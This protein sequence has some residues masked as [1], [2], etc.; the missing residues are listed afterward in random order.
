V[1]LYRR[2]QK[3]PGAIE[4]QM[5][6]MNRYVEK[7]D[8]RGEAMQVE[9]GACISEGRIRQAEDGSLTH[10]GVFVAVAPEVPECWA[11]GEL[12]M[13]LTVAY[14]L[15]N[16]TSQVILPTDEMTVWQA[17]QKVKDTM[18]RHNPEE[19]LSLDTQKERDPLSEV[20]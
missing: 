17:L 5:S 10:T 13:E 7:I 6:V 18:M 20:P 1:V 16:G 12:P 14:S 19:E 15:G 11:T 9:D 4:R 2:A 8:S 3:G